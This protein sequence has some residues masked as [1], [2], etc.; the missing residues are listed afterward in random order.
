MPFLAVK[1]QGISGFCP[2]FVP[3]DSFMVLAGLSESN[4]SVL[5]QL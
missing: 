4:S 1:L 2:Y 5:I 3:N